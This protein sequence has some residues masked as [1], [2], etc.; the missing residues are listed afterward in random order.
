M[1]DDDIIDLEERRKQ[2]KPPKSPPHETAEEVLRRALARARI[3]LVPLEHE[4]AV[5][6]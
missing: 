5:L 2:S 3:P 4:V 6:I 1:S